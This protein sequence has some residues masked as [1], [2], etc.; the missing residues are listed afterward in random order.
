MGW[1]FAA[2]GRLDPGCQLQHPGL[3]DF[4]VGWRIW[5]RKDHRRQ[6]HSAI[7]NAYPVNP[8]T[9][10]RFHPRCPVAMDIRL[11]EEPQLEEVGPDHWAACFT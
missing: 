4:G 5:L 3:G 10:C 2:R 1:D 11:Q 8:P 9:G 6:L 7:D